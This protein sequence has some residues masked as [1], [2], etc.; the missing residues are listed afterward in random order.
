MQHYKTIFQLSN[1]YLCNEFWDTPKC[2]LQQKVS[3][4]VMC[5]KKWIGVFR[6][7]L[8]CIELM[9]YSLTISCSC[10]KTFLFSSILPFLLHHNFYKKLMTCEYLQKTGI[11]LMWQN[12]RIIQFIFWYDYS[13]LTSQFSFQGRF[14]S[15]YTNSRP[16]WYCGTHSSTQLM[17]DRNNSRKNVTILFFILI[18][19]IL[20][21]LFLMEIR[22]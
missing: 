18:H 15:K 19:S 6:N 13:V 2:I 20:M 17:I 4:S 10:S 22:W 11:V 1:E 21:R 3:A 7:V 12:Q 9:K 5:C 16:M 8:E 14:I